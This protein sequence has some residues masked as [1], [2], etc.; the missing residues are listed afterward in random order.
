MSCMLP[1]QVLL[2]FNLFNV[3]PHE[4]EVLER[5]QKGQTGTVITP[6]AQELPEREMCREFPNNENEVSAKT[7]P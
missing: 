1:S 6:A 5:G 2:V 7:K 3:G 4:Q